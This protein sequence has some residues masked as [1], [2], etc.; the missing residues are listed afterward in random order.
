MKEL[1]NHLAALY[2]LHE[3]QKDSVG[4]YETGYFQPGMGATIM[5]AMKHLMGVL[6]PQMIGLVESFALPD[7]F[8]C[9]AIGNSYGDI[10]E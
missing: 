6:R 7:S 4:N 5:E 8:L 9:S 3:L 2:A 10:Y 1:L